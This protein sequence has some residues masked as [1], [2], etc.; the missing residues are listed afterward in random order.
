M[1]QLGHETETAWTSSAIFTPHPG[2]RAGGVAP[3]RR[4]TLRKHPLAVVQGGS[5]HGR[6][7]DGEV[8]LDRG[9]VERVDD[10]DGLPG[11]EARCS[12]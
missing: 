3:P 2:R 1:W 10:P 8:G 7:V 4:L 11:A 5:P 12:W 9:V 6:A